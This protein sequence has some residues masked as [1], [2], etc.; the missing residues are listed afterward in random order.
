MKRILLVLLSVMLL[1]PCAAA[2]TGQTEKPADT[3]APGETGPEETKE[4][5]TVK[6]T[7]DY[8]FDGSVTEE[9]LTNYLAHAVTISGENMDLSKDLAAKQFILNTGAKYICRAMT[10]WNPSGAEES[11]YSSQEAF[12]K[13]VHLNDPDVVFEACIFE[14]I[15]KG[16]NDIP[17]PAFVFEAFG[18][19]P[20]NRNFSY[21]R[22][23]FPDGRYKDQWGANTTVPDMTQLE[24][25]MFFYY[26]AARYIDTGFEALHLGQVHLIGASDGGWNCWTKVLNMIREYASQH[27]RRH[28]VFLNAHTHGIIG[29]DGYL[30]FDFHMYPSRPASDNRQKAHF[31][32]KDDPQNAFFKQGYTDAIYGKSLG[33]KTHSGWETDVLPYLVE[34]DN[35]GVDDANLNR[36]TYGSTYVWGMD[37]I[38]WFANQPDDYRHEFLDYANKWVTSFE[39]GKSFFAMPC[40]RTARLYRPDG[41]ISSYQYKGFDKKRGGCGDEAT[42][43][44]I[45]AAYDENYMAGNDP[46]KPT[47]DDPSTESAK[48]D[49][50]GSV[51]SYQV[52]MDLPASENLGYVFTRFADLG[53]TVREGDRLEYDVFLSSPALSGFGAIDGLTK[54]NVTL[55]DGGV[56][57]AEGRRAHPNTDLRDL[58]EGQWYHRILFLDSLSGKTIDYLML[59]AHPERSQGNFENGEYYVYYDNIVITNGGEEVLVV[60][61]DELDGA[62][63]KQTMA[64][65][66]SA[67][68]SVVDVSNAF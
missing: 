43:K 63:V 48:A 16:V 40:E 61:D 47:W 49:P 7:I 41:T 68:V 5:P 15:G 64:K 59:A 6:R 60:F 3:D 45:W 37:E 39:A 32:T 27:A 9:V 10:V 1:L 11:K 54:E 17:I 18:L 62:K 56:G 31:P 46:V 51:I 26:R 38:T 23:K 20:E 8:Q 12:I 52:T 13:G 66:A 25:Q 24:T 53:Y 33:G 50:Q 28:F 36:P 65:G 42:I 55:R 35:F 67:D 29:A 14:C 4:E 34:L 30:L 2:C 44:A 57:D 19:E 58:A 22:M 21:D